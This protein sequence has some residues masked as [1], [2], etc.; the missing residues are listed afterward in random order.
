[1]RSMQ[2]W[3]PTASFARPGNTSAYATG[4]LVANST[5]AA[6]VVPLAFSVSGNSMPGEFRLTRIRL[7]KSGTSNTNA[8][9]RLHLYAALP[10]AA[11]GDGGA[12]STNQAANYLG[13]I[14]VT[15]MKSF[16][17]GCCDVGDDAAGAEHLIRLPAGIAF[18]G[19]LEARAAY[20]PV[21]GEVFTVT[22]E[23]VEEW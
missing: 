22:L 1:M 14:D 12:W 15:S 2:I 21:A 4:N 18:Y 9:F 3:N 13:S 7:F 10:V 23:M 11:N 19:L 8:Q 17:D 6:A 20:T 16:T 5:I